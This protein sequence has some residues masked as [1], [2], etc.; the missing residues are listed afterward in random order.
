MVHSPENNGRSYIRAHKRFNEL[1]DQGRSVGPAQAVDI[2]GRCRNCWGQLAGIRGEDGLW[3]SI[4]CLACGQT[5]EGDHADHEMKQM[6]EQANSN[7]PGLRRGL[8][9]I[10][11]ENARFVL[12]VLP[13]MDRDEAFVDETVRA[14]LREKAKGSHLSRNEFPLGSAGNLYL[15]ACA[16]VQGLQALPRE[17]S[18][19]PP[20]E[21][22]L[23]EM[24]V[25]DV[26]IRG[27]SGIDG[28]SIQGEWT[29]QEHTLVERMGATLVATMSAAFACELAIK[30]ILMTR[31]H[32]FKM[33]HDLKDLY[34]GLPADCRQR[35]EADF[36]E[37]A[38][39]LTDSS[40]TF[41]RWRYF[42]QNVSDQAIENLA[43]HERG[44]D[45]AKAAR[46]LVD[47]GPI[48]GLNYIVKL[49]PDIEY[50][51]DQGGRERI[52]S[53]V[54]ITGSESAI[55]WKSILG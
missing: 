37:I 14:K 30:A 1:R 49:G 27:E 23:G 31:N 40:Q 44:H 24:E 18:V 8:P 20:L 45:L 19:F 52:K 7:L 25:H 48:A 29:V 32:E 47:E 6:C 53:R 21:S 3:T 2:E 41:G 16:L 50:Q 54:E 22:V 9:A 28:M 10:Y 5:V 36:P 34:D 38:D 15:Q 13:D 17:F 35:L 43:N 42:Q 12:K 46:V 4:Q 26:R 55:N 51:Y 33:T 11:G 39:V